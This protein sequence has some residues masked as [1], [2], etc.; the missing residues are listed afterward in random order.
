MLVKSSLSPGQGYG[1]LT[2]VLEAFSSRWSLWQL[3][4]VKN[5]CYEGIEGKLSLGMILIAAY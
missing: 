4:E 3:Q 1:H 2:P 5:T